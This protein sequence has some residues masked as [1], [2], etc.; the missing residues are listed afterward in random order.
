MAVVTFPRVTEGEY[1][2]GWG[3][4]TL[5][6]LLSQPWKMVRGLRAIWHSDHPMTKCAIPQERREFN[7]SSNIANKAVATV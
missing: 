5:E 7:R 1:P 4:Y 3:G 2:P 6:G